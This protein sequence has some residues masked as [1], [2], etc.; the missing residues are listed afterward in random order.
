MVLTHRARLLSL[1]LAVG[2]ALLPAAAAAADIAD[3]P[4]GHWAYEAVSQLVER[5]YVSLGEDK[6]FRG[7]QP[8]DRYTLAS[9]VAK[10]IAEIESGR[11]ATTPEDVRTLRALVDELRD[12]LVTYYADVQ[13][14]GGA[15]DGIY[16]DLTASEEAVARI[17]AALGELESMI[18]ADRQR[19][20]AG[21]AQQAAALRAEAEALR[22][23]IRNE[24][25]ALEA[26]LSSIEAELQSVRQDADRTA[27][28]LDQRSVALQA[29]D[30]ALRREVQTLADSLKNEAAALRS[31]TQRL[32]QLIK[33]EQAQRMALIAQLEEALEQSGMRLSDQV[34]QTGQRILTLEQAV[35]E[36]RRKFNENAENLIAFSHDLT[37][38]TADVGK[39]FAAVE[40]AIATLSAGAAALE[41]GLQQ[42]SAATGDQFAALHQAV[43]ELRQTVNA[44]SEELAAYQAMLGQLTD[45]VAAA[46]QN[47][48]ESDA[49]LLAALEE[50][51]QNLAAAQQRGAEIA[52]KVTDLEGT[53]ASLQQDL[54]GRVLSLSDESTR[55]RRDV[56][57]LRSELLV[58]QSQVGLSEE[59]VALLTQRVK[60][61][62][63][64]QLTL[65]LTRERELR[66]AL[67]EL[68]QEFDSYRASSESQLRGVSTL[69]LVSIGALVLGVIG[70]F[71]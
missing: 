8:V 29:A 61:D 64:N 7:D 18:E 30:E 58:L 17:I 33:S 47:L 25:A 5:G 1:L 40:Q 34:S 31:E 4:P 63:A 39:R 56:D 14:V 43:A 20:E 27:A 68:R 70:L 21:L 19:F 22:E 6:L 62:L 15:L 3:V 54:S 35:D 51:R 16:A 46:R 71:N 60:E 23:S 52:A 32:D 11:V 44:H 13:R 45:S 69:Q 38:L 57:G 66:T 10:I 12:D 48:T 67:D 28:T 42:S 9:V 26:T 49:Q 50:L 2:L 53:L 55:L 37:T 41:Q 65:S 24:I 36:L 59:Q